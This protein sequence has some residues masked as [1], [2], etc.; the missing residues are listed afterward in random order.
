MQDRG[1]SLTEEEL[2][3][4]IAIPA[5]DA[6]KFLEF[7]KGVIQ[8]REKHTWRDYLTAY[9][10]FNMLANT[11]TQSANVVSNGLKTML[12]V[13]P[14]TFEA[15]LSKDKKLA[16]VWTY[17]KALIKAMPASTMSAGGTLA[18]G[19]SNLEMKHGLYSGVAGEKAA[20][21][22]KGGGWNPINM[23]MRV[24]RAG[25][26]LFSDAHYLAATE[27]LATRAGKDKGL[28]G[29][30][31]D[32]FVD[33][34]KLSGKYHKQALEAAREKTF[35]EDSETLR[36]LSSGI[37]AIPGLRWILPFVK[38]PYNINAAAIRMIPGIGIGASLMQKKT[39]SRAIA[40]QSI[41]VGFAL[42]GA[43]MAAAG[44]ATGAPPDDE[45]GKDKFFN[46]EKKEAYSV[47]I[48]GK[49]IKYSR[50]GPLAMPLLAGVAWNEYRERG[51]ED[52]NALNALG[53][54]MGKVGK[55]VT[56]QSMLQGLNGFSKAVAEPDKYLES[57]LKGIV[58]QLVP[59]ASAQ[60]QVTRGTEKEILEPGDFVDKLLAD[61]PKIE[62]DSVTKLLKREPLP[63]KY[64]A[65][66]RAQEHRGAGWLALAG[67]I[68]NAESV[69]DPVAQE[70]IDLNVPYPTAVSKAIT[71]EITAEQ[72]AAKEQRLG[73]GLMKSEL[74][75]RG[76]IV[77][78]DLSSKRQIVGGAVYDAVKRTM[79]SPAYKSMTNNTRKAEMLTR[80]VNST[81]SRAGKRWQRP[82]EED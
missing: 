33:E 31:L 22:F 19:V 66:G 79:N 8:A 2:G 50:L 74:K 29:D 62:R 63:Q 40:E 44:D 49:W 68:K 27:M 48:G 72:R 28:S 59:A 36:K 58:G 5:G 18:R 54:M 55:M 15:M 34:A 52:K 25:D 39:V 77:R 61:L 45:G 10:M 32:K 38:T 46:A 17:Y 47:K 26:V 24:T 1:M 3:R 81:K 35:Q 7:Q 80:V 6:Q 73:R 51:A 65:L 9:R 30:A 20:S 60:R 13:V 37:N 70:L 12:D 67:W 11:S 21:E 56:D 69:D 53:K 76:E 75:Q 4:L 71:E 16:D 23:G 41:G 42:M 57:F 43:A 82:S 14:D 64:D 78:D